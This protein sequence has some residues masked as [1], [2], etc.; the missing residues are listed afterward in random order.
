MPY[1][2]S[3]IAPRLNCGLGAREQ[4]NLASSF[5]DAS[6]LY[7]NSEEESR[8]LRAFIDGQMKTQT[9]NGDVILPGK[10]MKTCG[11]EVRV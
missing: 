10:Q 2:R 8:R 3:S 7:G 5:L 11:S 9:V 6:H 4:A 1:S